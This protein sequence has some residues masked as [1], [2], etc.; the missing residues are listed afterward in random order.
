MKRLRDALTLSI[1]LLAGMPS[2]LT[3]TALSLPGIPN[4]RL[5]SAGV[6]NTVFPAATGG[7][8]PYT[9]ALSGQPPGISFA[10][11]TRIASGTLPTVA[12]ETTYTVTYSVTD[13]AGASASVSFTATVVPPPAPP[14]PPPPPPSLSL[15]GIPNFRLPSAGVVNT[16]FPAAT[17]GAAPYTYALSGQPPGIS[18]AAGTRIASG[19]LPTVATET[20]YTVTYSVSGRRGRFRRR[21]PSPPR[22]CRRPRH[23]LLRHLHRALVADPRFRILRL[24]SGRTK[25]NTT[26]TGAATGGRCRRTGT[27]CHG[28]GNRLGPEVVPVHRCRPPTRSRVSRNGH[29][30]GDGR[31]ST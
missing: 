19:T 28:L 27:A 13:G 21:C 3:A 11:G 4:F 10:A 5:P 9:Y 12:T 25:M 26:L 31:L 16:V 24:P 7:A 2:V 14:P 15:P 18:F 17:G 8:A 20:T 1:L 22:W 23:L 29:A 30:D 6:V